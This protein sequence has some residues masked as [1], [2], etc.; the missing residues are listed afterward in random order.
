MQDF[1]F[2]KKNHLKI[3]PK[4]NHFFRDYVMFFLSFYPLFVEKEQRK[5]KRRDE[6][7]IVSVVGAHR[8]AEGQGSM[9]GTGVTFSPVKPTQH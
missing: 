4:R 1:P 3:G 8:Q 7:R 6:G 2:Q 5:V 9:A